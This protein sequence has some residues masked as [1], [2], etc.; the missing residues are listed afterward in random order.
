MVFLQCCGLTLQPLRCLKLGSKLQLLAGARAVL[1]REVERFLACFGSASGTVLV[2]LRLR[3][4]LTGLAASSSRGPQARDRPDI[5]TVRIAGI[6]SSGR[7][8]C[9]WRFADRSSGGL[10]ATCSTLARRLPWAPHISKGSQ[11][12][13][14]GAAEARAGKPSALGAATRCCDS[15][16]AP[17]KT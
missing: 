1:S 5:F 9:L 17:E 16:P 15:R 12:D 7:C 10:A 4:V 8:C 6:V 3:F 13:Q 2:L 11:T 14:L